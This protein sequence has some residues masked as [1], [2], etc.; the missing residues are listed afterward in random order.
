MI[1]IKVLGTGCT[2]CIKTVEKISKIAKEL[3]INI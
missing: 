2:K 1:E 3:N